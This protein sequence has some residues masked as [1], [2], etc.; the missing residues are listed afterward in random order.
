MARTSV[1]S[2]S[3]L[4]SW[5]LNTSPI[6]SRK[7]QQCPHKA[8]LHSHDSIMRARKFLWDSLREKLGTQDPPSQLA[9]LKRLKLTVQRDLVMTRPIGLPQTSKIDCPTRLGDDEYTSR[10]R[11]RCLSNFRNSQ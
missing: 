7:T 3:S 8:T 4:E 5:T 2:P 11:T 1:N 9:F 6:P 10:F